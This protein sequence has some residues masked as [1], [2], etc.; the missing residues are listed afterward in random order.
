MLLCKV[1]ASGLGQ[2]KKVTKKMQQKDKNRE[3]SFDKAFRL[4]I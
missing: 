4:L 2:R 3:F 1:N